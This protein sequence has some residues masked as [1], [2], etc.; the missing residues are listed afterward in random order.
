MS[1]NSNKGIQT[2]YVSTV[3]GISLVLFMLGLVLAG[4]FALNTVQKQAKESLEGDVFF[5]V[6]VNESD[7]KQIESEIQFWNEFK[8]VSFISSKRAMED[9]TDSDIQKNEISRIF[10]GQMPL[11]P[12]LRFRPKESYANKKG[13]KTIQKKLL[14]QYPDEIDEVHYDESSVEK[15]NLG[16][17]QFVF[18]FLLIALFLLIVA[19]AMIN[20][21][22]RLALF[23]KRFTIKTMQLVGAGSS[24]IRRPF[25]FQALVQ[26]FIS[27][28]IGFSLI[29]ILFF[30]LNSMLKSIEIPLSLRE[31]LFLFAFLILTGLFIAY[32]STWFSLNKYLKRKLDDLY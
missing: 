1:R 11:P 7:I 32:F 18:L 3:V 22:I 14:E 25:L 20:N 9:F 10:E 8:N 27:S 15:V 6:S 12:S 17:K 16:F 13:M 23:S 4:Y 21:T 28:I 29:C 30:A 26:G 5:K 2:G 24:F 19:I 31:F